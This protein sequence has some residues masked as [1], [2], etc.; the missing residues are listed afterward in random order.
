MLHAYQ[1]R[2]GESLG[3]V[4]VV[5]H[6]EAFDWQ[7]G[8]FEARVTPAGTLDLPSGTLRAPGV[9]RSDEGPER[10]PLPVLIEVK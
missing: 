8:L 1:V 10:G 3:A 7:R 2:F 4:R 6:E 5:L 9:A